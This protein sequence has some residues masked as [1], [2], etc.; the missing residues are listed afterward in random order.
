MET[1]YLGIVIFLF[2]LAAFDL[3]VGVSNDAV[4]FL[5]SAIGSKTA[6]FRTLVTIA[7][8]GV[9][10][11]CVMSNGMMDIARHGILNPSHYYFEEVM[12]VFLAVMVTDIVLLDVFNSLGM[13]TS[14][15]VSMVFELMGAAF[16]FAM[17][18]WMQGGEH[19]LSEYM[20]TS[21]AMEIV[22]SIF[23]SVALAFIVGLLVMY[24]ARLL[25]TFTYR[26][27]LA[28][29]IGIFG[30]VALT[31]IVYFML[32]K[33][34]K[35][36]TFMTPEVKAY[37][38]ENTLLLLGGC[39]VVFTVLMQLLHFCKVNVFRIV[40][41][42]GT[43]ALAMAFAGNDL[44]NFLGVPLA[45]FSS[46]QDFFAHPGADPSTFTMDSLQESAT[47]PLYFLVGAGLI[48]V[49]SL[50]TS[51]KAHN[52]VK[53]EVGL[54]TQGDGDEMFGSSKVARSLVRMGNNTVNFVS[55][56]TP[57]PVA[58][59]VER[60]FKAA[61][62]DY[63]V[64]GAAFDQVR[65]SVNLVVASLLIA[66]GTSLKLPLSTTYVTFMVAM[67]S[68]LA[69]RAWS[70]ESA[71]F[72]ITG[73]L[74]VIA[75]WFVTAGAAF[76]AAFV[77]ALLMNFGGVVAMVLIVAAAIASLVHSQRLFKKKQT[78][79]KEG[80]TLFQQILS[81]TDKNEIA[82]M[83]RRHLDVSAAEC[84][85]HYAGLLRMATDGL[86]EE[87]LRYLRQ[88]VRES[89][90]GRRE[91]KNL[92]RRET[93][94]LRRTEPAVGVRLNTNFHLV[95]NSLRQM[96]YGLLRISEPAHEHVDNNF[97]RVEREYSVRYVE[98]RD[99]LIAL[100]GQVAENLR[101]RRDDLNAP[102]RGECR[103][104]RAEMSAFRDELL[105]KVQQDDVNITAM[106]LLLHT[107]QETE[108]L[109]LELR[110]L[111]KNCRLYHEVA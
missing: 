43:F 108:Q 57:A 31:S 13:P 2:V 47:T 54:A 64:Q 75:G 71:V 102:L 67:G 103:N 45:G 95:H 16:A 91:L 41:L 46:F 34:L 68:S 8:L 40:V 42:S 7:G 10:C 48:M 30:G 86:I 81:C 37:I 23:L 100:M 96:L 24:L 70:R 73:V 14:T 17:L 33:G 104:L 55:N 107:V 28:W 78:E 62:P 53:T 12:V 29:K 101:N 38:D 61:A 99:R 80:D 26:R 39:F 35:G 60:R 58:A 56:I 36:I 20:N 111:I 9:F 51:K 59:F 85:D 94:C 109:T 6:K 4:N 66:L 98:L 84:L 97:S 21:K 74:T 52:V 106:T 88:A 105:V 83:L 93:I 27:H 32:F 79:V 89:N 77:V 1:I 25:F 72:R 63:N 87:K 65:A 92:R 49:Y 76:T 110:L 11:G 18:K 5:N 90:A 82:P 50:A 3:Y 69:D 15:T 19:L 44:V 22:I